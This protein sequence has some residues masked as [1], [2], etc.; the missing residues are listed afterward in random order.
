VNTPKR[1]NWQICE[2]IRDRWR[3]RGKKNVYEA[4]Q[5]SHI[6]LADSL[7]LCEAIAEQASGCR[8]VPCF[9][10]VGIWQI[11]ETA[12]LETS[13]N[14]LRPRIQELISE[15]SETGDIRK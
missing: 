2:E 4:L 8:F 7:T 10:S 15:T 1:Q 6:R 5:Y 3:A 12:K 9:R 14:S 13:E 11:R